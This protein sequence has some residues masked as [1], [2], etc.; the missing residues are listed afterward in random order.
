VQLRELLS[1]KRILVIGD[2]ILDHYIYGK[3][4]RVSPEA[5]VP[6][7]V[8]KNDSYFLGGAAN[9]AQNITAFGSKCSLLSVTGNDLAKEKMEVLCGQKK[10]ECLLISDDARPTTIK[11]RVIGNDHQIVRIDEEVTDEID[12]E[13]QKNIISLL[14]Q[15]INDYDIVVLQDYDKGLLT[16][17]L[18][19]EIISICN[20]NGKKTIVDPKDFDIS[21]YSCCTLIK[22]NLSEFKSM[23]GISQH[24][25]VSREEIIRIARKKIE[26]FEIES[27]LITMA[28][29]GMLYVDRLQSIYEPGIKIEVSDVSGAGD[30]VSAVISLCISANVEMKDCIKLAN[31]SGSLVCQ[32]SGAVQIKPEVLFGSISRNNPVMSL[33]DGTPIIV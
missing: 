16:R 12:F 33:N 17:D 30:T 25:D 14:N 31:T 20:Q 18:I 21:K 8:K 3:V 19:L 11:T 29:N 32:I 28:E 22:P 15:I 24:S 27:F 5:P 9:V 13:I 7:V 23:S 4:Y 1:N 6:V 26:E 2:S 10:I